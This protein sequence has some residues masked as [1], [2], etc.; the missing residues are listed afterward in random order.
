[1]RVAIVEDF[2]VTREVY[3]RLRQNHRFVGYTSAAIAIS[4]QALAWIGIAASGSLTGNMILFIG[5][6]AVLLVLAVV[7]VGTVRFIPQWR[8]YLPT[9]GW[10]LL[11]FYT[12][13]LLANIVLAIP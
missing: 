5:V 4:V 11:F 1:M 13:V 8:R 3:R 2:H 6:G 7:K 9:F 10:V 12:L